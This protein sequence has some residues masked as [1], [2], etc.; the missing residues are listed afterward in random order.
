[1]SSGEEQRT[2]RV[3]SEIKQPITIEVTR[4]QRGG[5]GWSIKV[6]A[7]DQHQALYIL[8]AIEAELR[9]RYASEYP[10]VKRAVAVGDE[11]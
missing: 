1:M 10:Q 11:P 6:S 5:Y 4:G 3:I 8:D 9:A 7:E 2:T